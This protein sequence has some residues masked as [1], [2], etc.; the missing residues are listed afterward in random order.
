MNA[1]MTLFVTASFVA[2]AAS[3]AL[4]HHHHCTVTTPTGTPGEALQIVVGYY[5]KEADL[6]IDPRTGR[7]LDGED[8]FVVE[9]HELVAKGPLA[10]MF[11]GEG[12]SLTAD[13]FAAEGRIDGCDPYYEMVA[14]TPV[15][16]PATDGAWCTTDEN[17]GVVVVEANSNGSSREERSLH[18]G[19]GG[20]PHG[21]LIALAD[22][23]EYDI[24][25]VAWDA[26]G[27][28][29]DSAPVILRVHA[30]MPSPDFNGDGKVDGD[31]LGT[32]LGA[33]GTHEADLNGDGTTDGDDL[34]TLLGAWG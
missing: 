23:G 24:T 10:G 15:D 12:F 11:S 2:I 21:Q 32:L 30:H 3:P 16:G 27:V 17:T 33:W 20:H 19:F 14:V 8:P 26:N 25:L 28:F 1:R 34:G 6:S 5:E 29:L 18:V 22:E 7:I 9:L 4:A 13:F 31:D